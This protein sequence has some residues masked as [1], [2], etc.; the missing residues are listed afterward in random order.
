MNK[1]WWRNIHILNTQFFLIIMI[2]LVI[3]SPLHIKDTKLIDEHAFE[4]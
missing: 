4:Y 2:T 3:K 1:P